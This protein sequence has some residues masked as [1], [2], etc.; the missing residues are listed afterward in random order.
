[1]PSWKKLLRRMV[2]DRNPKSYTYDEAAGILE[3]LLFDPP[4]NPSGSHRKFR[5]GIADPAAPSGERGVIIGLV[6]AGSGKMNPEY[7]KQMVQ[8]LRDNG[9]LPPDCE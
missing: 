8:T 2:A 7:I 4:R 5:R 6:D 3:Q 1:M 9:L